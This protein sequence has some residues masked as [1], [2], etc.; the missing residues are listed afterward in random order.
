MFLQIGD[1]TG[2]PQTAL[3][4]QSNWDEDVWGSDAADAYLLD[5]TGRVKALTTATGRRT[6][7]QRFKTGNA[8]IVLDNTDGAFTFETGATPPGVLRLR[9]G[10][11]VKIT[12]NGADIFFGF[13][14]SMNDRYGRDGNV[15]TVIVALD[16]FAGFARNI[17]P[18]VSDVGGGDLSP[19]RMRR[20]LARFSPDTHYVPI[21]SGFTT[22]QATTMGQDLLT[23]I[24]IT[25]ESEGGGAWIDPHGT[26]RSTQRNWFSEKGTEPIDWTIG[27]ISSIKAWE[28]TTERTAQRILN[29]AHYARRGGTEQ[30]RE[31]STSQSQFGRRTHTRLDLENDNDQSVGEL[32]ER[33]VQ[34]AGEDRLRLTQLSFVPEPGSD[35]AMMC[36]SAM[37][38]DTLLVTVE[39][40]HGWAWT[41]PTQLFGIQHDVTPEAWL[42][43]FMVDDSVFAAEY[44]AF[45]QAAF[46]AQA[47]I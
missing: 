5:V 19:A 46:D 7:T 3:W 26:L 41:Q 4:D 24:Q 42:C 37:F 9:P 23:L 12:N 21:G 14:D 35:I 1:P 22:M 30:I 40:I 33:L 31:N 16:A 28:V 29:E 27:G 43:T 34:F 36:R 32:A 8:N 39:T 11:S 44:H 2:T 38:G 45:D 15:Q 25:A 6:F 18:A 17:R 10:R 20:L 47:F 13:V